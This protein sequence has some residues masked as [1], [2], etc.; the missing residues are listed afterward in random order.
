M[1]NAPAI[2]RMAAAAILSVVFG[3]V[4]WAGSARL[5]GLNRA[6]PDFADTASFRNLSAKFAGSLLPWGTDGVRNELYTWL[7][8]AVVDPA[9]P[10]FAR[11]MV[12]WNA[13][14]AG[15]CAAGL[16]AAFFATLFF[17]DALLAGAFAVLGVLVP[18]TVYVAA[19]N[20]YYGLFAAAFMAC[21][22]AVR[23]GGA[24]WPALA[25]VMGGL[26]WLAKPSTE[27]LLLAACGFLA[28]RTFFADRGPAIFPRIAR[29]AVPPLVLLAGALAVVSPRMVYAASAFEGRPL[30]NLSK[31][32]FWVESWERCLESYMDCT[33][34]AL[35]KMEP[36]QRP[37]AAAYF[38]RNGLAAGVSRLAGG[39]YARARQ[40]VAPSNPLEF[41]PR[42]LF[43]HERTTVFPVREFVLAAFFVICGLSVARA[44]AGGL[45]A[46]GLVWPAG[47]AICVAGGYLLLAAW[48]FPISPGYRFTNVLLIPL[49]WSALYFGKAAGGDGGRAAW[50]VRMAC[51]VALAGF[52]VALFLDPRSYAFLWQTF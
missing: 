50:R 44:G 52:G 25:G 5:I 47:F 35:A 21:V 19:E 23:H 48:Y 27:P 4:A 32:H 8:R 51:G 20:L 12:R 11:A 49:A 38:A 29:A 31:F 28:F 18:V 22:L 15:V 17:R 46:S 3:I 24:G 13:L 34:S 9:D 45:A 14:L 42:E 37:T 39:L 30:Y 26:A 7:S 33:P 1:D 43:G 41:L 40:L 6:D 10:G 16:T 36:L 2:R